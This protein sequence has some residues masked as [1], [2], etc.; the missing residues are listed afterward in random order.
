MK[1]MNRAG[2]WILTAA[3]LLGGSAAL[4]EVDIMALTQE[5]QKMSQKPSEMT[6]VWWIPEEYW[7]A[8]FAQSPDMSKTQIDEFL[9]AIR[10]YTM[11]AIVDGEMGSFGGVTYKTEDFVRANTKLVDANGK[12]YAPKTENDVSP[13]TKN[14]LQSFKPVL[15]NMLGPM[16]QNMHFLLFPANGEDGKPI[17]AAKEKGQFSVVLGQR[18]F[19]W[20]LPLDSLLPMKYCPA[21][22]LDCKGSWSFCPWCGKPVTAK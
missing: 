4:A 11:V 15:A 12:T 3:V 17:A 1:R 16:G 21:C 20:R 6:L 9:K 2:F 13:D 18:E 10:P 22:K 8:S 14:I 5:T 7:V 19:K